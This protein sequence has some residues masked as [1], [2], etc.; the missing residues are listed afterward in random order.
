[1]QRQVSEEKGDVR[2]HPSKAHSLYTS[3]MKDGH[4][5]R[6]DPIT[7]VNNVQ[8]L[9]SATY[10]LARLS[11]STL[12]VNPCSYANT[13]MTFGN[14]QASKAADI[15]SCISPGCHSF[16]LGTE[17]QNWSLLH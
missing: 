10:L 8:W 13:K 2:I 14:A 16:L 9:G 11:S 1:M 6:G 4:T 5:E 7:A 17:W 15:F 12:P 3:S